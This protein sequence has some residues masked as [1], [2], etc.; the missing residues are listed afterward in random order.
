MRQPDYDRCLPDPGVESALCQVCLN[1]ETERPD[2]EDCVECFD[3]R[4]E[5]EDEED[6]PDDDEE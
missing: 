6:E 2:D 3:C 5:R 4:V 1:A